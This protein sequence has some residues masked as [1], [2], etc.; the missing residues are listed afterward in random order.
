M[1]AVVATVMGAEA[2]TAGP[3]GVGSGSWLPPVR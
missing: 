1:V 2:G 3:G